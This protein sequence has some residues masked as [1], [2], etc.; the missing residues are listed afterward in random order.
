MKSYK[1]GR[2]FASAIVICGMFM[3]GGCSKGKNANPFQIYF[4]TTNKSMPPL[5]MT[6]D[7]KLVGKLTVLSKDPVTLDSSLVN[8]V[9]FDQSTEVDGIQ[10]NGQVIQ[11]FDFT[12]N[13]D[14][15]FKGGGGGYLLY[16][17]WQKE[18][19]TLLIRVNG[20]F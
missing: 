7:N 18:K 2:I 13:N 10:A 3:L 9:S 14:G 1:I 11:T 15:S 4:Y 19:Y 6:Y 16:D 12:L 8:V 17:T 20:Q 5:Y